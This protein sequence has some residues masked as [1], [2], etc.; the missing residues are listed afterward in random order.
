MQLVMLDLVRTK[1]QMNTAIA[2]FHCMM[3]ALWDSIWTEA[4]LLFSRY[5]LACPLP[6]I[7]FNFKFNFQVPVTLTFTKLIALTELNLI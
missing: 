2:V 5:P 6:L 3:H 7:L 1:Q 4:T